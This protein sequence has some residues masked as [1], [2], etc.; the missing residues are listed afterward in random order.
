MTV[1]TTKEERFR[2]MLMQHIRGGLKESTN[3]LQR[4]TALSP[5]RA[6]W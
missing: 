4:S 5:T 6:I 1:L 3:A 2:L